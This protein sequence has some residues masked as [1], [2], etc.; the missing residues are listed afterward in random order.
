M[1]YP[2]QPSVMHRFQSPAVFATMIGHFSA[3]YSSV[4]STMDS[5][6]QTLVSILQPLLFHILSN[7][8]NTAFALPILR[9]LISLLSL[10]DWPTY[11]ANF[12]LSSTPKNIL[13]ETLEMSLI[14]LFPNIS[15]ALR[16][17]LIFFV[18]VAEAK[19]TFSLQKRVKNY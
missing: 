14:D 7:L 16:I 1:Q 9:V 6:S 17:F 4:L 12:K 13:A 5:Y 2:P 10:K 3:P 11:A 19:R 18:S 15:I 8:P